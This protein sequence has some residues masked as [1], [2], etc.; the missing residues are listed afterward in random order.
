MTTSGSP[1]P[2]PDESTQ[3][4][5]YVEHPSWCDRA[6]CSVTDD[7]GDDTGFHMSS[8]MVVGP[9]PGTNVGA[10]VRLT[11]LNPAPGLLHE[12]IVLVDLTLRQPVS[13]PRDTEEDLIVV[14]S[15]G[16]A[17]N[18]GRLLITAGREAT[19]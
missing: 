5:G 17:A 10:E 9:D 13:D 12:G 16:L 1:A 4:F 18:L 15:G 14:L 19:R 3:T 6:D 2:S 7:P 8:P 11:Q